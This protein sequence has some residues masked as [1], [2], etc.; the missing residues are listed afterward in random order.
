MK[1]G[2]VDKRMCLQ[3]G[4]VLKTTDGAKG[5]KKKNKKK[6]GKGTEH[7]THHECIIVEDQR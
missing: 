5:K 4:S 2:V 7:R 1:V 6:N 3:G